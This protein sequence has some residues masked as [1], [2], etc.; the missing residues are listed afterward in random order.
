VTESLFPNT[1]IYGD[2]TQTRDFVHVSNVVHAILLAAAHQESL[3]G[4][5]LNV[6]TGNA[7]SLLEVLQYMTSSNDAQAQTPQTKFM[8]P[9]NGDM[10][11]SCADISAIVSLLGFSVLTSTK[12]GLLELV[13]PT[14]ESTHSHSPQ[15]RK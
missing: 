7:I 8:P 1:R 13:S 2:G 15:C 9:R 12:Q 4:C 10:Q 11:H 14:R 5:V 6:G 3:R